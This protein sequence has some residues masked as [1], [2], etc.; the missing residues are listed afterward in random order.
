MDAKTKTDR[1]NQLLKKE[2][3]GFPEYRR[4]IDTSG[5]NLSWV[6]RVLKKSG[7]GSSELRSL[8]PIEEKRDE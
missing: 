7:K 2:R 4:S 5:R 8:L 6:M 3:L 1:I